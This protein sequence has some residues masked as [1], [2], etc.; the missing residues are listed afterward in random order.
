MA[1]RYL[2]LCTNFDPWSNLVTVRGGSTFPSQIH[3]ALTHDITEMIVTFV[4]SGDSDSI[5]VE[6]IVEYSLYEDLH[7][8]VVVTSR[9]IVTY[10]ADD[11]C[12]SPANIPIQPFFRFSNSHLQS[13]DLRDPG[14]I[15]HVTLK[16]LQPS[17]QYFYRV[18]A[19]IGSFS[20]IYSF[21]TRGLSTWTLLTQSSFRLWKQCHDRVFWRYGNR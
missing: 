3:I 8:S 20:E 21:R 16:N 19:N 2:P 5:L 10:S 12:G 9:D 11:M 18:R 6:S 4:T 14:L 13:N 17:T 1:T 15:H 7:E